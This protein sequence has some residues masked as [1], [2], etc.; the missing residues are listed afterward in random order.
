[1]INLYN[2]PLLTLGTYL[3]E[4]NI[5][6][7]TPNQNHLKTGRPPTPNPLKTRPMAP[8]KEQQTAITDFLTTP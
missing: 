3:L 1:M 8:G 6:R 2:V 4:R 5:P 7:Q